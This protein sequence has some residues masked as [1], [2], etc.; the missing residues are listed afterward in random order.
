MLVLLSLITSLVLLFCNSEIMLIGQCVCIIYDEK[1]YH[2]SL[3]C[4]EQHP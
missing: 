3:D 4:L 2:L 1:N